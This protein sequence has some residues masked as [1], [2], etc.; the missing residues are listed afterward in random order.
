[1]LRNQ[2]PLSMIWLAF[3]VIIAALTN[4][5]IVSTETKF[6]RTKPNLFDPILSANAYIGR[7]KEDERIVQ[8]EP[9]LYASDPDPSNTLNGKICGYDLSLHKHDDILDEITANIPFT[10]EIINNQP[11]L[12]LKSNINTLD[13]EIKQTYRLFIRAFDC[14]PNDKRRYSERSSLIINVDD[15]NEY[16]PVFTH[17]N[18]LFKLHQDQTCDSSSCRVEATDDDCANQDHHVCNYEITTP[19]VPFTIDSN[20]A[21]SITKPLNNHQY[22]FDVIAIDCYSSNDSSRKISQ[23]ARVTFKIISSCKPMITGIK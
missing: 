10:I 3:F 17:N 13:C 22:D 5:Q 2:R 23:P 16:A 11:I 4:T 19:N 15:I 8:L 9:R 12:K 14:A 20:G 18:Y 21:I 6:T 7:I 1:M